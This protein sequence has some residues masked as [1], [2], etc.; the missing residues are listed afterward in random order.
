MTLEDILK[1]F[2]GKEGDNADNPEWRAL[3]REL[4]QDAIFRIREVLPLEMVH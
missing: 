3:L 4:C 2:Q 1:I